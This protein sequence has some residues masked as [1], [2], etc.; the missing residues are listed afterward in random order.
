MPSGYVKPQ[1]YA[2]KVCNCERLFKAIA[3]LARSHERSDGLSTIIWLWVASVK[4][5]FSDYFDKHRKERKWRKI[6]KVSS[7]N[8]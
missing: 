1:S 2:M 8:R 6:Y 7:K 3:I 5:G 4:M